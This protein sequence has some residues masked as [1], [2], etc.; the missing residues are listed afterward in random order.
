[1]IM[2]L[3]AVGLIGP[4]GRLAMG[5][6]RSQAL[7]TA[8]NAPSAVANT[9]TT[10]PAAASQPATE[11]PTSAREP[12]N[13]AA[14]LVNAVTPSRTVGTAR[15]VNVVSST[16]G[17]PSTSSPLTSTPLNP[18]TPTVPPSVSSDG[19]GPDRANPDAGSKS[20]DEH[21]PHHCRVQIDRSPSSDRPAPPSS[22]LRELPPSSDHRASSIAHQH[23]ERSAG[24]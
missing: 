24:I 16:Q 13:A 21:G 23:D 8:G 19:Q 6:E 1:L 5:H 12:T 20:D 22:G 18:T 10:V 9:T 4:S 14:P 17:A 3:I 7:G 11:G 15:L 2:L